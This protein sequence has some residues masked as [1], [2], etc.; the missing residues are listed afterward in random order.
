MIVRNENGIAFPLIHKRRVE[1]LQF[2]LGQLC[3]QACLHCHIDASP[4]RSSPAENASAQ[5]VDDVLEPGGSVF[6][7]ASFLVEAGDPHVKAL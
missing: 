4:T 6:K 3:N 7:R 5:L 2:N 1:L